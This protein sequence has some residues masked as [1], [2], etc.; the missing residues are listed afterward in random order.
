M[1]VFI[2]GSIS[3]PYLDYI[4]KDELDKYM[5]GELEILIGDAYGVDGLVQKYMKTNGYDNV[6]IYASNGRARNN[7]GGWT[8]KAI[9]V[10]SHIYGRD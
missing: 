7:I 8:V 9:D 5:S 6:T 10:P 1:K 2:S 4:A 3:I